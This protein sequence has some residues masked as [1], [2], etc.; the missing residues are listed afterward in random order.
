MRVKNIHEQRNIDEAFLEL[1]IGNIANP[2][3]IASADV[4]VINSID[5]RTHTVNGVGGLT[6]TF[7]GNREVR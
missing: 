4:K 5:P 3:L 7:D 6:D 1:D 2:D